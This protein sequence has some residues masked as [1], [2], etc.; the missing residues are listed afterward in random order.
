MLSDY[1][2]L[3]Q[4][5]VQLLL[6]LV[7]RNRAAVRNMGACDT[8]LLH[9]FSALLFD[10]SSALLDLKLLLELIDAREHFDLVDFATIEFV[11]GAEECKRASPTLTVFVFDRFVV[12]V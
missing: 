12:D 5:L 8:V 7:P 11:R 4:R 3:I 6:L 2:I 1:D 10:F 9:E